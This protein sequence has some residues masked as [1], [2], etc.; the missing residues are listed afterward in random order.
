M[1]PPPTASAS[2][3]QQQRIRQRQRM[4]KAFSEP[5]YYSNSNGGRIETSVAVVPPSSSVPLELSHHTRRFRS[6][7]HDCNNQDSIS[8]SRHDLISLSNMPKELGLDRGRVGKK[9]GSDKDEGNRRAHCG[10]SFSA[11]GFMVETMHK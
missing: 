3:R 9:S 10:I 5:D 4:K 11:I 6:L 8:N 7:S 1:I 2:L